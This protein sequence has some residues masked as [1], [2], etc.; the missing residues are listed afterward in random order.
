M[1]V[2]AYKNKLYNQIISNYESGNLN[3]QI[4]HN[5][6]IILKDQISR[7]PISKELANLLK[8]ISSAKKEEKQVIFNEDKNKQFLHILD[9]ENLFVEMGSTANI[10]N[11]AN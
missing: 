3:Y 7:N 8:V 2:I 1:D 9:I 5:I 10:N 6:K 4:I 11:T